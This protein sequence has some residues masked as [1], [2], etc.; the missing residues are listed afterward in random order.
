MK[1]LILAGGYATR[2]YPLTQNQAK[3][4]IKVADQPIVS[5]IMK[6]I[7]KVKEIDEVYVVTNNRFYPDF[8]LWAKNNKFS[9]KIKVINDGTKSNETRLGAVGDL[10]FVLKKENISDDLLIIAGDNLFGF[11]LRDFVD[12]FKER[13][14][15]TV[16]FYDMKD[17]DKVRGKYGVG[18]LDGSRVIG[19]EEKPLDPKSALAST[20]CY[21][22]TAKDLLRVGKYVEQG[23]VDHPGDLIKYLAKESEMHGFVFTEHWYD[24]GS[25]EALK[26]A[27]KEYGQIKR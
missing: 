6:K 5:H 7:E 23:K 3:P 22:L 10:H 2:L 15:S 21:L 18:I 13:K 24:I 26:E 12:F 16:A 14:S 11:E 9:K 8:E 27:E 20:A 17:I 25:F 19:F 1:A 4:L